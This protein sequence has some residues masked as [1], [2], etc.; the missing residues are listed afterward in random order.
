[1][2]L[3]RVKASISESEESESEESDPE[4][5]EESAHDLNIDC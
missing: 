3:G 5:L 4:V 2:L 1:M